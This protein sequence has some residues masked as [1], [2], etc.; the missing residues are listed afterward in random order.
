MSAK[1][2]IADR[3][4]N[5]SVFVSACTLTAETAEPVWLA[6]V[7]CT[8]TVE[9]WVAVRG[10][11]PV[12]DIARVCE[13]AATVRDDCCLTSD[14]AE[15]RAAGAASTGPAATTETAISVPRARTTERTVGM[16]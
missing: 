4:L 8:V 13:V 3:V 9:F 14:A 5:S 12:I 16:L 7:P 2:A 11:I 6:S 15:A 10:L 1:L